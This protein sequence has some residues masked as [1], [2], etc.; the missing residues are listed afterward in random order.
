MMWLK[1]SARSVLRQRRRSLL[2][3]SGMVLGLLASL[4]GWAMF[5]GINAQLIRNMTTNYTGHLQIQHKG[6][7][8]AGGLD[9]S[10]HREDVEPALREVGIAGHSVRLSGV[11]LLA[12]DHHARG[13]LLTGVEPEHETTVTDLH[14][15][16]VEG[17]YLS[18]S[19]DDAMVLGLA[20]AQ[21]L[22]VSLGDEVAIVVEGLHGAIGATRF[23]VAGIYDSGNAMVDGYQ[24]FVKLRAAEALFSAPGRIT[25]VALRLDALTDSER[26]EAAVGIRLSSTVLRV[27]GWR[28]LL[29]SV[30]RTVDFHASVI[31]VV[32]MVLLGVIALGVTSTLQ[33]GVK[34]RVREFGVMLSL[35]TSP[36]HLFRAIVYEG[37]WMA[38]TAFLVG[39]ATMA[40]TVAWLARTGVDFSSH[41]QAF[42]TM[43]GASAIVVPVLQP[44]R[45]AEMG[46]GLLVI[47]LLAAAIP[48]R[49]AACIQPIIALRGQWA[50]P[51]ARSARMRGEP[52]HS[53]RLPL[54]VA[55]ALRNLS[56]TPERTLLGLAALSFGLA[57]FIFVA[58][59]AEGFLAQ[60]VRNST[61]LLTGDVQV[62]HPSFRVDQRPEL[63]FEADP[64]WMERL[65]QMPLVRAVS[66][67]V[68]AQATL[69]GARRAEPVTLMG[70][71]PDQ[72]RQITFLERSIVRGKGLQSG[73]QV[74]IGSKLAERLDARVGEKVV[75][76]AQDAKGQLASEALTVAGIFDTGSH[77]PD[78]SMAF[79]TLSAAQR[80]LA[81]DGRVTNVLLRLHD[82]QTV[83]A[84]QGQLRAMLPAN[85]ELQA[86]AWQEMLPEV[87]Q[88]ANLVR[89]GL[90]LVLVIVFS[91]VSVVVMN[92]LLMSVSERK[93]EFGT[94]LAIGAN[95]KSI[96]KM[97]LTEAGLLGVSGV[98]LGVALGTAVAGY[99]SVTGI[100]LDTHGSDAVPGITNTV[101]PEL[102]VLLVALP[103]V[104]LWVLM[105]AASAYPAARTA[106]LD[107]VQALRNN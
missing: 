95:A 18:S 92:T 27:R 90:V 41:G 15:K 11:G 26:V 16:L 57:A 96:V 36:A 64:R 29:P 86:F 19:R 5:D 30:A 66:Q 76:T 24:V 37:L 35:G 101:H 103:A 42:S 84:A 6:Y 74:L 31:R 23:R 106:R 10:F 99:A 83:P 80:I 85:G 98:L 75:V 28:E 87:A 3:C 77:G 32:M 45:V 56:R 49:R 71:E 43:Q 79:V 22:G 9:R 102:S 97:V 107:P 25:A 17:E 68:Q 51:V 39:W 67:R 48:A 4:W 69:G 20:L 104:L 58:A 55:L 91:M 34:E 60:M 46:L 88:F 33:M 13:V 1:L 100:T 89:H 38:G 63:A 59:F 105:L 65:R 62:Q 40:G 73:R 7:L 93:L 81:L 12:S 53:G 82:A 14:R 78:A 54:N 52:Q 21:A 61:G 2:T 70:I 50:A 44:D 94:L 47:T 72:E 8:D